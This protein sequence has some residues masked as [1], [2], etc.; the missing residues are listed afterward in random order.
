MRFVTSF[1][2]PAARSRRS[3]VAVDFMAVGVGTFREAPAFP[4]V[5]LEK[6]DGK[7]IEAG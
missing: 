5:I 7:D 4:H 3:S 2:S 6:L 1:C